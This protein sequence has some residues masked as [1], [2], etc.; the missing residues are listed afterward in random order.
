[1]Q[2]HAG[3]GVD[4]NIHRTIREIAGILPCGGRF[5]ANGWNWGMNGGM[6]AIGY[7]IGF[8]ASGVRQGY[9]WSFLI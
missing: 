1:M 9:V 3:H 8:G 7:G 2:L 5:L 4:T 6:F